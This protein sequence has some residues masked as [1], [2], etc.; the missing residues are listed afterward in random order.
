MESVDWG[1]E[2][3]TSLGWIAGVWVAT[4][5]GFAIVA[6]IIMRSLTWGRQFWRLAGPWIDPRTSPDRYRPVLY[7]LALLALV[8]LQVRLTILYTYQTN[9]LYT[10][11]QNL[12][13]GAFWR[14]LGI[15]AVIAALSVAEALVTYYVGQRF[16]IRLWE[17]LTDRFL[18]DWLGDRV[19]HRSR[20]S[21]TQV[22]N[23]DQRIQEDI[24]SFAQTSYSLSI[25]PS[26]AVQAL[27]TL[28]SFTIILWQLSGPFTLL[29]VEIPRAMTFI[30]FLYVIVATVFAFRIG[31]PLIRL[32]FLNE[33]LGAYYRYALVRVR[34]NAENIAFYRGEPV[35]RRTLDGRFSDVIAN[36]WQIVIRTLKFNGF[37]LVVTQISQVFP[38]I[39]QAPRFF[40]QQI[41]LGDIQQTA[42]AFGQVHDS[43][44]FFRNAYDTFASY[45]AVLDRLTGLLDADQQ[46]RDLP[47]VTAGDR[48]DGVS[49][50]D[51]TVRT[52]DGTVLVEDLDLTLA[53]A[54]TLLITGRSGYGKTTLLRS[55][56]DLW[57]YAE[58]TVERPGGPRSMFLSQ[59][60]YLPLGS[61]RTALAYPNPPETVPDDEAWRVLRAVALGH[62]ADRLDDDEVWWRTLSPGEQQ[63][64]GFA[65]LVLARPD[66]VFLD[67]ATAALDEGL[68]HEL[69]T[70]VRAELPA[71]VL[72]SVG[73]R[74]SL[75][76]FHERRLALQGEGRWEVEAI[77]SS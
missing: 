53:Q 54:D 2:W 35:E 66:V 7:V 3:L 9:D 19:Y 69:Y 15:F 39:L 36:Y 52:P 1:T 5:I 25:G 67:E 46:A 48:T 10:A 61:L 27:V 75:E 11:L 77:A 63:R 21:P 47:T 56:A 24:A 45:R 28:P 76:A 22:D 8:V 29:G 30:A 68:E 73:H 37:N 55:L 33:G 18:G 57:P 62:L 31:K 23:P 51:L 40:A 59:Q 70:L 20:F 43:L 14:S 38:I 58:G 49:V 26:G 6:T 4:V 72:V 74:S 44:S 13:A 17:Y 65:R 64:L 71:L 60:P 41:S 12:D 32:N 16:L 42:Q 50:S 34:D